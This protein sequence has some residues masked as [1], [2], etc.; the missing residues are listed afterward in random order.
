VKAADLCFI[1]LG[2]A[3]IGCVDATVTERAAC[4]EFDLGTVMAPKD[5]PVTKIFEEPIDASDVIDKISDV[6]DR[7]DL[8]TTS[9]TITGD[10]S[11]LHHV[12]V[13]IDDGETT[14]SLA[15]SDVS[16]KD[17]AVVP[18]HIDEARLLEFLRGP[19][20]LTFTLSGVGTGSEVRVTDTLCVSLRGRLHEG[21]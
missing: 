21:I 4:K 7:I 20:T 15:D 13:D 8:T 2:A 19:A 17:S 10:V 3:A 9:L 5:E 1:V 14:V 6:S 16:G 18:T 12:K 11:W